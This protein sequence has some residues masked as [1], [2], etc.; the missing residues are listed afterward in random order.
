MHPI[1]AG[2][3]SGAIMGLGF[4]VLTIMAVRRL[5]GDD[6]PEWLQAALR[7]QTFFKLV[8]PMALFTHSAWTL[9]GL[10]A[11]AVY[12]LLEG[13]GRASGLGSPFL[14][15][16]LAVLALAAVYL[17]ATAAAGGRVRGWMLPSPVLFAVTFGWL[18]PNLAG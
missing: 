12:W 13:G 6:A 14:W 5:R 18:L 15:Y 3:I 11:G 8:A 17:L 9:A 7:Q 10:V 1:L 4:D 2:V 16:T